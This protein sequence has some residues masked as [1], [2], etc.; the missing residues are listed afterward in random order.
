MW[1]ANH[2]LIHKLNYSLQNII[3]MKKA[4]FYL[5]AVAVLVGIGGALAS[6]V[7]SRYFS[8]SNNTVITTEPWVSVGHTAQDQ[9]DS[10]YV[11]VQNYWC[12]ESI[13]IVCTY[14]KLNGIWVQWEKGEFH[15]NP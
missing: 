5:L 3:N 8:G 9:N 15:Q 11:P 4:K 2:T 1:L 12:D 6:K 14:I 7:Q 10:H 13:P